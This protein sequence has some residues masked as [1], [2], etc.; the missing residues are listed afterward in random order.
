MNIEK[1]LQE[2]DMLNQA[3]NGKLSEA[4]IEIRNI[5]TKYNIDSMPGVALD[6]FQ[7]AIEEEYINRF[8]LRRNKKRRKN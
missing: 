3:L 6:V 7:Y 4:I 8:N 5:M 1:H 2:R